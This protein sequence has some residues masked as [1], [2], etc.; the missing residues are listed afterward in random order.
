MIQVLELQT[1]NTSPTSL[2]TDRG[3][4]NCPRHKWRRPQ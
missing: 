2:Q 4:G 3:R 1:P